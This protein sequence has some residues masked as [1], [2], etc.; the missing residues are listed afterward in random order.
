MSKQNGVTT[1]PVGT[2]GPVRFHL[3]KARVADIE[4]GE[5]LDI[6]ENPNNYKAVA[7][8]MARFLVDER[9]NYL[10][11]EEARREI[12]RVTMGQLVSAYERFQQEAREEAAPNG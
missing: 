12:R 2:D 9:G 4:L 10:P 8:L 1:K 6:E 7:S 11:E 3:S 5:I